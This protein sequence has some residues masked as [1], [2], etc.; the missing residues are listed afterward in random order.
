MILKVK[1]TNYN[2]LI[3]KF[4]IDFAS[5]F[6]YS[7]VQYKPN[8]SISWDRKLKNNRQ[9]MRANFV[10]GNQEISNDLTILQRDKLNLGLGLNVMAQEN[11]KFN[12]KY[13]L[14][15]ANRYIN[16]GGFAE[17]SWEF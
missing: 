15:Y 4:G 17:Y 9:L 12:F 5:N 7:Q 10:N 1:G 16:N 3:S 8:F 6:S 13:N 14:Q 11:H 2:E